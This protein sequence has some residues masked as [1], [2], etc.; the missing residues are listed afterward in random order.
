MSTHFWIFW[1]VAALLSSSSFGGFG[2]RESLPGRSSIG[3][4]KDPGRSKYRLGGLCASSGCRRTI[5]VMIDDCD[6]TLVMD[7][8]WWNIAHS[9]RNRDRDVLVSARLLQEQLRCTI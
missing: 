9:C 3:F 8:S 2:S 6:L 1:V 4:R 5:S 7:R